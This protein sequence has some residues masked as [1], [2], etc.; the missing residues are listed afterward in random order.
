MSRHDDRARLLHML[1]HA[2][3]AVAMTVGCTRP[4]LDSDRQL[5]LAL[6]RLLEITGEAASRVTP[7]T[8]VLLPGIPWADITGLRH[9]V[10]HGYD[11]VDLDV[12]WETIVGDLPHLIAQLEL[13][14]RAEES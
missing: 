6:V 7:Q 11:Q 12:V 8:Q 3:E 1:D 2:R 10:V 14:L 4:D 5:N 13:Y 9:R